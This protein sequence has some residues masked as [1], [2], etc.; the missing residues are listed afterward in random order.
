MAEIDLT[1]NEWTILLLLVEDKRI[2][3]ADDDVLAVYRAIQKK[4]LDYLSGP[5]LDLGGEEP[6]G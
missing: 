3:V 1:K 6:R 5:G 4:L 2:K